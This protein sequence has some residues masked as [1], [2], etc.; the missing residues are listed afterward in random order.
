M[1]RKIKMPI[2]VKI[3]FGLMF[4]LIIFIMGEP[5]ILDKFVQILDSISKLIDRILIK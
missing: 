5:D 3:P 4:L 1:D 2:M